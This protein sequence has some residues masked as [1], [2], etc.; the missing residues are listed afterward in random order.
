MYIN[1]MFMPHVGFPLSSKRSFVCQDEEAAKFHQPSDDS[2]FGSGLVV[3]LFGAGRPEPRASPNSSWLHLFSITTWNHPVRLRF[4]KSLVPAILQQPGPN[5]NSSLEVERLSVSAMTQNATWTHAN[6][7]KPVSV[8]THFLVAWLWFLSPSFPPSLL[9]LRQGCYGVWLNEETFEVVV[10]EPAALLSFVCLRLALSLSH[11]RGRLW[12]MYC[13]WGPPLISCNTAFISIP[14]P[15]IASIFSLVLLT[16]LPHVLS[17][18]V[19]PAACTIV[20]SPLPFSCSPMLTRL[21]LHESLSLIVN[22]GKCFLF[23]CFN[24]SF[25]SC[26]TI[27]IILNLIVENILFV[28]VIFVMVRVLIPSS[29]EASGQFRAS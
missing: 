19:L 10:S 8:W 9:S 4:V 2:D 23:L 5:A 26:L 16:V 14:G 29:V 20:F 27:A 22:V 28:N 25:R 17:V 11:C 3:C 1:I 7:L 18:H 15:A 21:L 13:L 12:F 24:V 6:T